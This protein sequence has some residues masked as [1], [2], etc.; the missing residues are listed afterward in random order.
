MLSS[1]INTPASTPAFTCRIERTPFYEAGIKRSKELIKEGSEESLS[2]VNKFINNIEW[3]KNDKSI[4]T[5]NIDAYPEDIFHFVFPGLHTVKIDGKKVGEYTIENLSSRNIGDYFMTAINNFVERNYDENAL[6]KISK[7]Q[8][9]ELGR[10][11]ELSI[12][13]DCATAAAQ[14][15]LSS[16]VKTIDVQV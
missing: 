15:K 2:L 8:I 12:K 9:Y 11:G 7:K 6:E 5:L 16:M 10:M 13:L 1:N 4:N 3:I 14:R